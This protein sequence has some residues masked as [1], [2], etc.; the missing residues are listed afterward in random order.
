MT[1]PYAPAEKIGRDVLG[2]IVAEFCLRLWALSTLLERPAETSM[3]FC[4]RGGLRIQM[5]YD[6]F[7]A[8]CELTTPVA[9]APLMVSRLAAVRPALVRGIEDEAEGLGPNV[10]STL[11]YEFRHSTV[12]DVARAV[13]GMPPAGR[14][15][16]WNEPITP[17]GLT[18]LFRH[19]D[20]QPLLTALRTQAARFSRH[21][22]DA[23]GGRHRV[24]LVD[25]GLY[26]TTRALV[27]EG[28]PDLDV[29][30]A[31]IARSYRP[32]AH[33]ERTFGLSVQADGYSPLQRR[34]ALLRYWHFIEWL[35]EPDL[36][37]V[38]AFEEID[39]RTLSDL[40][41][42][43]ADWQG[44]LA[45]E[46]NSVFAGVLAYLDNLAPGAAR[47]V[48]LDADRAWRAFKRAVVWPDR[49]HGHALQVGARSSGFGVETT[50]APR[51]WNGPLAALQ[52]SS[53]WREGEIARSGT[54]FRRPL[55]ALVEAAYGVRRIRRTL[56]RDVR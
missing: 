53:M 13:T 49:E 8:A 42:E 3:L 9:M 38:G 11:V 15:G 50:W 29:S 43:V 30:S 17:S 56:T 23:A 48:T 37:S 51:P 25:T 6:R 54:P 40:E 12:A 18:H 47:Q 44:R 45:P 33:H 22:H 5:A 7:L 20:G 34:T 24:I 35:F 31:L 19:A 10:A 14:G 41:V 52:G 2:P 28:L 32:G 16:P 27:A 55:L 21:L 46:P 1:R 26:G 4:A 39:G 36:P